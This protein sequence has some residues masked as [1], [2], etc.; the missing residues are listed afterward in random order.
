M[1]KVDEQMC[2]L[3]LQSDHCEALSGTKKLKLDKEAL[4]LPPCIS[5]IHNH[6]V[7]NTKE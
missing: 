7:S 5:P 1:Q 2:F 3:Y 4:L 6:K